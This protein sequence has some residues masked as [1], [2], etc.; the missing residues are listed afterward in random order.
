MTLR[1]GLGA[2]VLLALVAA[3]NS[4]TAGA[5]GPPGPAGPTG[6]TGANGTQG[7]TGATGLQGSP[8][9]VGPAQA[10][11]STGASAVAVAASGVTNLVR[12]DVTPPSDGFLFASASGFC[13]MNTGTTSVQW[14]YIIGTSATEAW[15]VP[16]TVFN[17]YPSG[18]NVN[19]HALH[20]QR[21]LPVTGGVVNSI[22]LNVQQLG[23]S[24]VSGCYAVL[25]GLFTQTQLP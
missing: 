2:A 13:G 7:L 3:C 15:S 8:G 4:P 21:V 6:P 14:A 9:P 16:H 20:V 23:G 12:L 11:K 25:T 19:Q 17:L 1:I 5:V 22:Y 18:L 10:F 24:P